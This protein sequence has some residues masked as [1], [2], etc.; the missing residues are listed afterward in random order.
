MTYQ[1]AIDFLFPLHRFGIKPGLDNIQRLCNSLGNP[2]RRLPLI[3]HIAGTN[4]K[5]ST[6][7]M[8][9]SISQEA[10]WKTGLYTSPHLLDFTERIRINGTKIPEEKVAELA[11]RLRDLTERAQAT[12]FEVTTAMA[13]R[14]FADERVDVAVIETGMGGKLDA[15]NIVLPKFTVITSIG[16]DHMEYL[17]ETLGQ[18][19]IEKAGI[20]KPKSKTF[21]TARSLDALE[22]ITRTAHDKRSPLVLVNAETEMEIAPESRIGE[23]VVHLKTPQERYRRLKTPL[24]ARYQTENLAAAV[25]I[26][27]E[28]KVKPDA[29]RRGLA[30][31]SVNTGH[32]ARLEVVSRSPVTLLD[33]S[34]N[35]DGLRATMAAIAIYRKTFEH[36]YTVFGAMQDKD[37]SSMLRV[38]GDESR[39]VFAAAPKTER[40][41]PPS[42]I[43]RHCDDLKIICKPSGSVSEAI[44]AAKSIATANDL[45]LIT[46]SFYLAAEAMDAFKGAAEHERESWQ[47]EKL[48]AQ[49]AETERD[50]NA[51]TT[52]DDIAAEK[53]SSAASAASGAAEERRENL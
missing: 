5:G 27:E 18:I 16:F 28:M 6:A 17:G 31:V 48:P 35:P 36:L 47:S 45:I 10:G 24:W 34:H 7:A 3:I 2:E 30:Y 40:A 9:A 20:I 32:R 13:F 51:E 38:L 12:F 11:G 14:H 53:L 29:I 52:T 43:L 41:M 37:V 42:E 1:D 39:Y 46:G 25:L 21:T 4:G 44:A 22:V 26:A 50:V 23:L 33:V 8:I 19:A 49:P 15:T